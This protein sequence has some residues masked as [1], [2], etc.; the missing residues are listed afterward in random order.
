MKKRLLLGTLALGTM[1]FGATDPTT[2]GASISDTSNIKIS[3]QKLAKIVVGDMDF[4]TWMIGQSPE[5]QTAA[6]NITDG[7]ASATMTIGTLKT[8]TLTETVGGT[9]T[10]DATMSFIGD[11]TDASNAT[12][13]IHNISL[14]SSGAYNGELQAG[15]G[16]IAG[17]QTIGDYEGEA[18][19]YITYN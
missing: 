18:T 3:I 16:T 6:I 15:I 4:T 5:N 9:A 11:G 19:V 14:N 7:T 2:D 17:S 10:I 8:L 13:S 1:V 12:N